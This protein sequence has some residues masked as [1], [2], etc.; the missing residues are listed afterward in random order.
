MYQ[1][2]KR[3]SKN[4]YIKRM[5]AVF[6]LLLSAGLFSACGKG[7][8]PEDNAI[9]ISEIG[10][11]L[12]GEDGTAGQAEGSSGSSMA[13]EGSGTG[14]AGGALGDA[15]PAGQSG[16]ASGTQSGMPSGTQSGMPSG[17]QSGMPSGTQS[18][19]AAGTSQGTSAD[20]SAG[21]MTDTRPETSAALLHELGC[22][23]WAFYEGVFVGFAVLL[24]DRALQVAYLSYFAI[25]GAYR[26]K[27]CGGAALAKLSEVY[28]DC[29]I[30]LDMERMDETAENYGQRLRRLAF[31]ERNG[32]RRAG[33]GFQYFKMDLEIMCNRGRFREQEFRCLIDRIKLPGFVPR[34]YSLESGKTDFR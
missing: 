16:T 8:E 34:L 12:S 6:V 32:Y 5:L 27:G 22:D 15:G 17:T 29:Q 20:A 26:S 33:V 2:S 11:P 31:Y 9:D 25:D 28:E 30:V 4:L 10:I 18:G 21:I 3:L 14:T 7:Q 1:K 23:A 24:S 19:T 13:P